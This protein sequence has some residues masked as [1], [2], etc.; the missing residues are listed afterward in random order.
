[1][2][3][4]KTHTLSNG[5]TILAEINPNAY[6]ISQGFF[7]Q[8][9]SRDE[10]PFE[11]GVSHFL[12]HML[13]KG[14]S[15]RCVD[16]VNR[17]FDDLGASFNACT[18]EDSTIF[19]ASFLPEYLEP[20]LDLWTDML[21]PALR[22]SDFNSERNVVLEELKMYQ[23]QPPYDAD[24]QSRKAFFNG[25]PLG[26]PII[27]SVESLTRMTVEI[28]KNY[29][30]RQYAPN[31]I[32]LCAAG[33]VDFDYLVRLAERFCGQ[34]E[35]WQVDHQPQA[36]V[37][38][39]EKRRIVEAT[40][41]EQYIL[42]WGTAPIPQG[43]NYYIAKIIAALIG[44]E[45]GSRFYWELSDPG[46]VDTAQFSYTD[47]SQ[48]AAYTAS[49]ACAPEDEAQCM[50]IVSN[51]Y[52]DIMKNGFTRQELDLCLHRELA[53][54]VVHEE[55]VFARMFAVAGDWIQR[56]QYL[57]LDEEMSIIESITLSEVNQLVQQFPL[58]PMVRF[59]V[60]PNN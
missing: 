58:E 51:I 4:F 43:R 8:T 26:N 40:A 56:K 23:D 10:R 31:N 3:Q 11:S 16:D 6:S 28:M 22:E 52:A 37:P 9:G 36:F 39:E 35:S 15:R 12:E 45:S 13:F 54:M 34:W 2:T 44:E 59:L 25:H 27:G 21:R 32:V 17:G 47:Y 5:L 20:I 30:Q 46:L 33:K 53:R 19:Y 42:D 50:E 55:K 29:F 24:E 41:S 48:V 14:T 38:G 18:G 60:G 7:V 57:T 1:M 49:F